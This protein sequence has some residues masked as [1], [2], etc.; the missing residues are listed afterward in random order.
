MSRT[1]KDSETALKA[2]N[3]LK[4]QI[5]VSRT[6]NE[7]KNDSSVLGKLQGIGVGKFLALSDARAEALEHLTILPKKLQEYEDTKTLIQTLTESLKENK[8][9]KDISIFQNRVEVI[10]ENMLDAKTYDVI[11]SINRNVKTIDSLIDVGNSN[12][13]QEF[14]TKVKSL[15]SNKENELFRGFLYH[16]KNELNEIVN[17]KPGYNI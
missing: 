9:D 13:V 8:W 2:W 14:I 15:E 3:S 12:E 4:N 7:I 11:K 16:Y 6:I 10:K 17:Y 1:F 5:G